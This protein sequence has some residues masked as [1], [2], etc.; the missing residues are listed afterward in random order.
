MD[1]FLAL[2][3]KTN[4]FAVGLVNEVRKC[5]RYAY[6]SWLRRNGMFSIHRGNSDRFW[7]LNQGEVAFRR[8]I[9]LWKG[10]HFL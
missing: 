2:R 1:N 4:R 5:F 3:R 8:K 9:I 7:I 10:K 6:L